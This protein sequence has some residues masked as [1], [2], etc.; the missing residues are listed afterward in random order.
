MLSQ[1]RCTPVAHF[2]D[3]SS[4]HKEGGASMPPRQVHRRIFIKKSFSFFLLLLP[5][6][7]R[8]LTCVPSTRIS[9]NPRQRYSVKLKIENYGNKKRQA[10]K[11]ITE[12]SQLYN[13]FI[14]H[15]SILIP[16]RAN[17]SRTPAFICKKNYPSNFLRFQTT[18]IRNSH[19]KLHPFLACSER[20]LIHFEKSAITQPILDN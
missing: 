12:T 2:L 20:F 15:P 9:P 8:N 17:I 13:F 16:R 5:S 19:T 11:T 10:A 14:L 4:G 18:A 1:H 6:A 3:C 7:H